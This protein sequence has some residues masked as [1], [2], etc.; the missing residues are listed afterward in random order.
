M[1]SSGSEA[2]ADLCILGSGIAGMLV[3][4][5]ALAGGRQVLLIERGTPLTFADRLRQNSHDDPLPFNRSPHFS[6]HEPQP[7]GPRGHGRQYA[8]FPVYN[9][10]G[11]TNHFY[12]NMPRMHPRHFEMEAFAG[13]ASRRWP[14]SYAELEPYYLAAESRLQISG[15]SERTPF[16]GRFAYPLPPHRLS[17]SDRACEALFGADHVMQVPTVRPPVAL[18]NRP[19]CCGSDRCDLCPVDSKGTALNTVFPA[20]RERVELRTG[21]LATEVHCSGRRV[22]AVTA[23]DHTGKQVRIQAREFVVACNGVDTPVLLLRSPTVPKH[24]SLGRH[25]MDHPVFHLAVYDRSFDAKPGYADSA[26]TGM[27]TTFFERLG[28]DLPVSLLGEIHPS[29]LAKDAG[30]ANR[31]VLIDDIIRRSL[32]PRNGGEGRL[33]ERFRLMWGATLNLWFQ[34]EPQPMAEHTVAIARIDASGQAIPSIRLRYP[35][36]FAQCV[37]RVTAYIQ[38]RLPKAEIRHLSTYPGSHHWMGATRMGNSPNDGSVDRDLRYH[39]LDNLHV[40][41]ASAFPSCSSTNPTLT[42]AA[43]ALRLGD[44]LAAPAV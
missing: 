28:S 43:L 34:I 31:D 26:Q 3:A 4:E 33:R 18:E 7:V 10:G 11:S 44:R 30:E 42:L 12:G 22:R 8:F 15:S 23:V 19:R 6:P 24:R 38:S 17:P 27:L 32:D 20:I 25:Y 1:A 35:S 39:G 16:R 21:L 36:Y 14:I 29:I 41:S 40:L 5:R 9:L 13:G 37:E 2:S